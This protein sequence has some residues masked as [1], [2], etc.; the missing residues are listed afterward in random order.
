MKIAELLK[1]TRKSASLTQKQLADKSGI[2]FVSINRI[3]GGSFPRLSV[4]EKLFNS[5]GKQ[6][7]F[8]LTELEVNELA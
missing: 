8:E 7:N 4:I 3:E 5:M 1:Q 2:S 6:I